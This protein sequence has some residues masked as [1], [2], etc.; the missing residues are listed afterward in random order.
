MQKN[1]NLA[2]LINTSVFLFCLLPI[3]L[4]SGPF[5]SDLIVSII[6]VIFIYITISYQQYKYYKN[7]FFKLFLLYYFFLVANSFFSEEPLVSLK[8][9][10]F[11][12]RFGIFSL[13]IWFLIE[14]KKEKIIFFFL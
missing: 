13:A 3:A 10:F 2:Y 8:V 1:I 7:I 14:K 11:Y 9:S 5:L 12:F 4:I 6:S